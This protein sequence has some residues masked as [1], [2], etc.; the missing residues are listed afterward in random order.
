LRGGPGGRGGVQ[1]SFTRTDPKKHLEIKSYNFVTIFLVPG[2]KKVINQN[3]QKW[4][5]IK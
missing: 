5:I 1:K 4:L 2:Y 3:N